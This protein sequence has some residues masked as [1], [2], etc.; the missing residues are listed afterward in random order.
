[1]YQNQEIGKLGE[2][3]ASSYLI[4]QGY[5]ILSRNFHCRLGEIDIIA[6]DPKNLEIVFI[7]VKT[8]RQVIYGKPAD[9]VDKRKLNHLYATAHYFLIK[10]HFENHPIRFDVIEVSQRKTLQ[11]ENAKIKVH[12]IQNILYENPIQTILFYPKFFK[13]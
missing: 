11:K 6:K 7:E 8:R 3:I 5:S 13:N 9:A 12:H 1:M 2:D 4:Q 10:N